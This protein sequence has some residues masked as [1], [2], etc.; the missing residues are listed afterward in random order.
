VVQSL[1]LI[2]ISNFKSSLLLPSSCTSNIQVFARDGSTLIS[3]RSGAF[4]KVRVKHG[5]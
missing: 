5:A 1:M 3:T 2:G 4:A